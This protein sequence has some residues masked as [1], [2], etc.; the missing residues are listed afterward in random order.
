M[1]SLVF[2]S[3]G[4]ANCISATCASKQIYGELVRDP[5]RAI[6]DPFKKLGEKIFRASRGE[7]GK[8]GHTMG[9][10]HNH[11]SCKTLYRFISSET[12]QKDYYCNGVSKVLQFCHTDGSIAFLLVVCLPV[13]PL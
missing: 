8:G 10:G 7:G 6:P 13:C 4:I 1:T 12:I 2:L 11:T 3:F 5:T 9:T